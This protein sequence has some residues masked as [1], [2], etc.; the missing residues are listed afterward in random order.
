MD[1]FERPGEVDLTAHVDFTALAEVARKTGAQV[2]PVVGQGEFLQNF[3]IDIRAGSLKKR[4][5]ESQVAE[6]DTALH[7]LTDAGQMGT[8]FKV[9]EVRG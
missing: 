4:A 1:I 2:S 9:M 8:L 3:G 6:I 7:R 5:T